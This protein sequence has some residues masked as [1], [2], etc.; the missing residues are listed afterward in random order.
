MARS[1]PYSNV[2]G[3][4]TFSMFKLSTRPS[5]KVVAMKRTSTPYISITNGS[6]QLV[7]TEGFQGQASFPY[8]NKDDIYRW[9]NSVI[10][11]ATQGTTN[12]TLV[13]NSTVAE[14]LLTNSS[15]ATAYVDVYDIVRKRD[16]VNSGATL[17]PEQA[18]S[19]G[20][21]DQSNHV[22]GDNDIHSLP[23]DSKLF[24]DYFIVKKR[25]HI[26]LAQGATHRHMVKLSPNFMLDENMTRTT[27]FGGDLKGLTVY[28]MIVAY[29]QPASIPAET[30]AVVTT[31]KIAIDVVWSVRQKLSLCN[32]NEQVF[33][34]VDNLSTL[35]GEQIISAGAGLIMTNNAV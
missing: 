31:A 34:S 3:Q 14:L 35:T 19:A 26:A 17:Y 23:T 5:K 16:A 7:A 33:K 28:S 20:V 2:G 9:F 29:G 4:G 30:G 22:G 1:K 27:Y 8:Q 32:N 21:Y 6:Y 12:R 25:T 24:Q 15:L 13:C 18:R 10:P 11:A